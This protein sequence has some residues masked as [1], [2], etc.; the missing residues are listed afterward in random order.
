[1]S[2]SISS[3]RRPSL[4]RLEDRLTPASIF[5]VAFNDLNG[6]GLRANTE[7]GLPGVRVFLDLNHNGHFDLGCRSI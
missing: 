5:G 2:R 6:D 7:P 4:L 3:P 1:M